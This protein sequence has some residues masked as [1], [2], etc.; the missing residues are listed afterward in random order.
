M[1]F[2]KSI[3][4]DLYSRV[5]GAWQSTL[6]G[7]GLAVLVEAIN[8]SATYLG[9]QPQPW[10]HALAAILAMAGAAL[11]NKAPSG[12]PHGF[13][14]WDVLALATVMIVGVGAATVNTSCATLKGASA[15]TTVTT[16]NGQAYSLT[17]AASGGCVATGAGVWM[18][19]PNTPFE[20]D[21]VCV[22]VQPGA[23]TPGA[24]CRLAGRPDTQFTLLIPVP[25][26]VT[27]S[28]A[29]TNTVKP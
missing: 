22:D 27:T 21:K 19:I 26:P 16:A 25:V 18:A 20:C 11:R 5:V 15:T 9:A 3:W 8:F 1:Q 4:S 2:L 17:V 14:R 7:F 24:T 13:A 12:P 29:S 23:V 6:I 28:P 10:A